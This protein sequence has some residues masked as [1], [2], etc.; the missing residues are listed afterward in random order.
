MKLSRRRLFELALGAAQV[1]L[2][3]RFGLSTSRA[4]VPSG[5]PTKIL[6]IWMDGGL[7]WETFFTPLSRAGIN[8]YIPSP[9]GGIIPFGYLPEQVENFDRS[10]ADLDAPGPVRKIRGPVFWN[11]ANPADTTGTNPVSQ[12]KQNYRPWGYAWADPKYKLYEKAAVLVGADQ[13]TAAHASGIVASMC[14][15]AGATFRAPA[16]QAVIANAMANRFPDRPIPN[17]SLGG[18][19]PAALGLPSLANPMS[20]RSASSVEPTLS[21]KR[22]SAWKGLRARQDVPDL[23]FDGSALPGTVPASAVD[24]ALLEVLRAERNISSS[25]TDAMLEQLYDMYK[26]ES[27]TIRRDILSTLASTP[28]WEKLKNDPAYPVNWTACI[29][30]A[31]SCGTGA[32]MGSYELALQLLKSDLVTSVNLRATSF[33][34]FSFDTHSANGVQMHTNHLRIALEMVGR[35]CIEMSLTPSKSDPSRS[36]LDE[37]LVYIYSDFGR[38]FP[39]Q[40]SDHHPATC[41][42]LVGGGIQGNQMLGGYDETMGGSPM[43]APVTLVEESGQTVTRAPRSQD[44]AATVMRAFGLEPGKDFFIPGGYGV[45]DGVV[46]T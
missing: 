4:A 45:F 7:H 28:T 21:D 31:D 1:G 13:N 40:G 44:M 17:V 37:T 29:G 8:K 32:A 25:G 22:D 15:V 46:K 16:V 27:R 41:A 3:A 23:A 36:L 2:M 9:Q 5:R 14:G 38:T 43:G 26:G 35:M 18:M 12:N 33:A 19:L 20:V 42:I 34:N 11:W 30:Y 39:K 10:P 24:A 6:G